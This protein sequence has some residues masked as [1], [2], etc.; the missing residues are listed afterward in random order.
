MNQYGCVRFI[1]KVVFGFDSCFGSGAI[2]IYL[3]ASQRL[4]LRC[5]FPCNTLGSCG[6]R[7]GPKALHGACNVRLISKSNHK[8][9][10]TTV[11]SYIVSPRSFRSV[12]AGALSIILYVV[13]VVMNTIGEKDFLTTSSSQAR[14]KAL[15][16]GP[17]LP[18]L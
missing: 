3:P 16:L 5:A 4:A 7:R 12:T 11:S 17:L 1:S 14:R 9:L 6:C 10:A 8:H 15:C 2:N 13:L 18:C